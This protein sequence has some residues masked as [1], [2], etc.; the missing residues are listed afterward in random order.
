MIENISKNNCT[1]CKLC[2][3]VCPQMAIS[4]ETDK[5]G[6]WYPKVNKKVCVNCGLCIKKCP[7]LNPEIY[8][9]K[10]EPQ[11]YAAWSKDYEVRYNSTSGGIFWEIAKPFI[12]NGGVVVGSRWGEDWKSAQ[13][14]IAHSIEELKQLRGS[15]YIQSDTE[16]IYKQVKEE[17]AIGKKI[18]FSG[19]PCQNAAMKMYVGDDEN[20]YYFDFICRS[21]NS[22][23][24]FK[25]YINELENQYSSKVKFVHLKNKK[26]GW[27]SLAS[28][29]VFENGDESL[30]DRNEDSWIQGFL[31]NDL[32]TRDCCFECQYRSL[33]RKT[34]DITVGDFWGIKDESAYDMFRGISVVLINSNKGNKLLDMASDNLFFKEK[35]LQDVLEGNF[36]LLKNPHNTGNRETFFGSL[37]DNTFS[38]SV[39][40]VIGH[41]FHKEN[42]I[43]KYQEL[44]KDKEKYKNRGIIDEQLY[45]DLNFNGLNVIHKG[46]GKI[47]PYVNSVIDLQ[48]TSQIIIECDNDFEIGTNLF[49]GSKAETLI[50]MGKHAIWDIK[51]GGYLFYGTT[52]EI[53]ENAIFKAGYFSANT[54][55][56]II[57]AKKIIFGEDVMI[58]RNVMIYDSDFH[59]MLGKDMQQINSPQEVI[60]EDHVWLTANININKG[61]RIEQ[62]SI[63]ANQTVVSKNLPRYSL[64]AGQSVGKVIKENIAWSRQPVKKY[65]RETEGK[66]IILYGY[67]VT[68]KD[69]FKKH[70]NKIGYI[71]DN[72]VND[73]DIMSFEKFRKQYS[74][75]DVKDYVWV[76]ASLNY[77]EDFYNQIKKYYKEAF[78]ISYSEY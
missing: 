1:G 9:P 58:G 32:F 16:G 54:G 27:Q 18:L 56:V 15:K 26:K 61:V 52:L 41:S 66:K 67:G 7:S 68:G 13:H 36:A 10:E 8:R 49:K 50:R 2:A 12:L 11:V 4:Y 71:I 39:E 47:I 74:T 63:I 62:G 77:Y 78:V 73:E 17:L 29:V 51:H 43:D 21:I 42:V 44:E 5:Y 3:D 6:L 37:K 19:T 33:P 24:A 48:T 20:I 59:Q 60:I 35:N 28:Q 40:K 65:I 14:Y 38:E 45:L 69:F 72:Y 31:G 22:P 76:I 23:L 55:S 57:A 30:K 70:V 75:L 46:K 64:V 25:E 34:S 53:K